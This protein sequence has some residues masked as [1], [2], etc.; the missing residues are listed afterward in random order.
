MAGLDGAGHPGFGNLFHDNA[1]EDLFVEVDHGPFVVDN[2]VFL[3]GVNL[4]DMSE[5]GAYAHNLFTGKIISR[6][7]PSRETPYHPAHS[8]TVAGLVTIKGGDDRFFNNIMAGKRRAR[9]QRRGP[10]RWL[11]PVGV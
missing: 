2:N 4:L 11:R 8:T 1:S 6:P 9:V 10:R 3:S 5:G 7:E